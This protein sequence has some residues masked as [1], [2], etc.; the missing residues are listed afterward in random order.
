[1]RVRS[2]SKRL[3]GTGLLAMGPIALLMTLVLFAPSAWAEA[4]TKL[5]GTPGND[6]NAALGRDYLAWSSGHEIQA[7][8]RI[9]AQRHDETRFRVNPP[10]TAG[11][12]GSFR[13]N[14]LVFQQIQTSAGQSDLWW[15]NLRTGEPRRLT[16]GVNTPDWEWRAT[17]SGHRLLFGRLSRS[18][19]VW[20]YDTDS[21][22]LTMLASQGRSRG[23]LIPG[24]I[25]GRYAV[26]T[27]QSQSGEDVVLYDV[28]AGTHHLLAKPDFAPLQYAPSVTSDGTVYFARSRFGCGNHV[29]LMRQPLGGDAVVLADLPLGADFD[30]SQAFETSSGTTRVVFG[31]DSG[32]R[33]QA[34]V[35]QVVD[36]GSASPAPLRVPGPATAPK[37]HRLVS[38]PD[39][40]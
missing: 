40:P 16:N 11:F 23:D 24:Q 2:N 15:S 32:C 19:D 25:A 33:G 27:R 34:D 38:S 36:D 20:L 7:S 12:P 22:E 31:M 39:S 37:L 17:V 1:M 8:Y 18:A 28:V 29:R 10:G 14:A 4:P 9:I 6:V 30:K 35:Y 21:R 13:G 3:R 5:V 26:W